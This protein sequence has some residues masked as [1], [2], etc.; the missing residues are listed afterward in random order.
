MDNKPYGPLHGIKVVDCSTFMQA[1]LA[2]GILADLGADVIKIEEPVRGD[3]YRGLGV[4]RMLGTEAKRNPNFEY[5][6][7]NRRGMT[8]DL[9]KSEGMAVLL[10]MVKGSDIFFH[11]FRPKAA[12]KMGIGYERLSGVNPKLIYV[13]ASGW[14]AK[15]AER[16]RGAF[17]IAAGARAGMMWPNGEPGMEMPQRLTPGICDVAG[18]FNLAIATLAA[19]HAR[20]VL[21]KG[22]CVD[23]SLFGS[24]IALNSFVLSHSLFYGS[25]PPRVPRPEALNPLYNSYKCADGEWIMLTMLHF[26]GHWSEFCDAVERKDLEKDPRCTD[27]VEVARHAKEV[28]PIVDGIFAQKP[29]ETWMKIFSNRNLIFTPIRKP[30]DIPN[31]L[32]V[33]E[34]GY[35]LDFEHPAYGH[36]KVVGFPYTFSET[37]ASLR[38]PC[39]EFG[40]HTEEVLLEYSYT[41]DEITRLKEEKVI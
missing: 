41:W 18:G 9:R 23:V 28:I 35:V 5:V 26:E 21:G 37:P 13:H 40:Q 24:A 16:E 11:N 30:S 20:Q 8:L 2:A 39:P 1:P 38:R 12:E 19:L 15:G 27:N 31:D 6:N 17:D 22:Q 36:Q 32:Q 25:Y 4:G 3:G 14:G 7:R 29:L 34:N 10:R 33:Q